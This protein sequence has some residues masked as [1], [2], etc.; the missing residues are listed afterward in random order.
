[1]T[2]KLFLI[3]KLYLFIIFQFFIINQS[4][5][6]IIKKFNIEGNNRISDETIIMFSNLKSGE[7]INKTK[8]NDALKELYYTDY[9]KDVKIF[10]DNE[11]INIQVIENPIIQKIIINGVKDN[12]LN[13]IVNEV[14]SK[15]LKYPL[16]E[17]KISD[18]VKLLK[19]ILKSY[20]YY[21]VELEAVVDTNENNTVNLTYNFDLGEIAKI[22]KIKF[23]GEKIFSDGT[24]RNIII[25]EEDK[26]WKFITRNNF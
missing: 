23:I 25:S 16:I 5:S 10:Q 24:L 3:K 15:V 4:Y 18:Q 6:E 20:G 1:M 12:K 14:T 19:N 2:N 21:S 11:I 8:L 26:F 13:D 17:S 22:K 9:F 7:K